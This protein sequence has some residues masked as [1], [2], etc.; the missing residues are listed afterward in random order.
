LLALV[1][2]LVIVTGYLPGRFFSRIPVATVFRTYKLKNNKWKLALLAI[3]FIG[4]SFVVTLMIIVS[5]QFSRMRNA[6]HGYRVKGVYYGSTVGMKPNFSAVPNELRA[7]PE[8]EKVG[9]GFDLPM[10]GASGNNVY[11]QDRK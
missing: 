11:S 2:L 8:V 9:L 5:I 7:M 10:H 1:I 3:Q 4:A 6:D